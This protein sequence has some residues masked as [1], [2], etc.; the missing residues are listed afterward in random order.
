MQVAPV[1]EDNLT[2]SQ[3]V[4]NDYRTADV[5]KK[6][7]INYCCGGNLPLNEAC[8]VQQIDRFALDEELKQATQTFQL[9]SST[10][11]AEWPLSF[12]TDYIIH[13][14]HGYVKR[15]LPGLK[16]FITNYV[17]GHLKKFPHLAGVQEGFQ[18][19]VTELEEHMEGEE[20]SI[21]PY[22]KQIIGTW[23]RQEVYGHLF[24]RTMSRP[25]AEVIKKEHGRIAF[26]LK[27]LRQATNDYSFAP[28]ACTNYQVLYN[29]LKEF[30]ADLVQ[31]KHLENNI[32][33]PK[34]IEMEKSL[35]QL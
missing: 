32:L 29:K 27:Q 33:F 16:Q 6:W 15:V 21:F 8:M 1:T 13:V 26:Q 35:L 34:A 28:D 30:D 9:P 12:L 10:A 11:F 20:E 7:G 17:P 23:S 14:H 22:I 19:L 2:V 24:V 31:H 4:R 18:N 5:F 25:L 3:I